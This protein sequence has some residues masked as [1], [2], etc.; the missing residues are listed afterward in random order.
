[1]EYPEVKRAVDEVLASIIRKY[2]TQLAELYIE[3]SLAPPEIVEEK[4]VPVPVSKGE[5]AKQ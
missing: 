3:S 1:M 2:G 4:T 5:E